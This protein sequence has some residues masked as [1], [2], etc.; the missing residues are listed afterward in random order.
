MHH[1][2][3]GEEEKLQ[4]AWGLKASARTRRAMAVDRVRPYRKTPQVQGI[5]LKIQAKDDQSIGN[6]ATLLHCIPPANTR[7]SGELEWMAGDLPKDVL[8]PPKEKL[9]RSTPH[10]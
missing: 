8:R 1:L 7:T 9:G 6:R 10:G 5:R 2:Y 3:K 4:V